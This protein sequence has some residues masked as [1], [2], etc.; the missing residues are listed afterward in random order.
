MSEL[1]AITQQHQNHSSHL[2]SH[3][4]MCTEMQEAPARQ[5]GTPLA[6]FQA[7]EQKISVSHQ[8]RSSRPPPP[9]QPQ[10]EQPGP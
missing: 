9:A 4:R 8:S 6:E 1:P 7:N 3:A 5:Q 2:C 10:L